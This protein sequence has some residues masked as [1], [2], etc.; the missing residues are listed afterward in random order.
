MFY[1]PRKKCDLSFGFLTL[2]HRHAC[3]YTFYS[4]HIDF[5][6]SQEVNLTRVFLEKVSSFCVE[7]IKWLIHGISQFWYYLN[8]NHKRMRSVQAK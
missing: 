1:V 4:N 3:I 5:V 6:F 8:C 2:F 7:V